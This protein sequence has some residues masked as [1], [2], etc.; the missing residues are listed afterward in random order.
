MTLIQRCIELFQLLPTSGYR[1]LIAAD[2]LEEKGAEVEAAAFREGLGEQR[3]VP[4]DVGGRPHNCYGYG[5]GSGHAARSFPGG[6]AAGGGNFTR[7]CFSFGFGND[8]GDGSG[9][10]DGTGS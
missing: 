7:Q 6:K 8:S 9:N 5:H 1:W 10:G 2:W 4:L 3:Q